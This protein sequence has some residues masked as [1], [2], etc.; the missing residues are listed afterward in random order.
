MRERAAVSAEDLSP[1]EQQRGRRHIRRLHRNRLALLGAADTD[2]TVG[3]I[4]LAAA[5]AA[6][7]IA[8]R[9]TTP[10]GTIQTMAHPQPS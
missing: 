5:D 9:G 1:V 6:S 2:S 8:L 10:V 7:W 3:L 4:E